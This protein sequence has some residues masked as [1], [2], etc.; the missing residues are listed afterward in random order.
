M[1]YQQNTNDDWKAIVSRIARRM[2][3]QTKKE[4]FQLRHTER[5]VVDAQSEHRPASPHNSE[6]KKTANENNKWW[7]NKRKKEREKKKK[8]MI[9]HKQQNERRRI[10]ILAIVEFSIEA[11]EA[12]AT[13][14]TQLVH[15]RRTRTHAQQQQYR[16]EPAKTLKRSNRSRSEPNR[17]CGKKLTIYNDNYQRTV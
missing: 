17:F 12:A 13:Q 2:N 11:T 1:F 5:Q 4:F 8:K 14:H 9:Q 15:K 7:K 6:K 16:T 10:F 3:R